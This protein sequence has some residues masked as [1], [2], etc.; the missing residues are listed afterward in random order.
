MHLFDK[1]LEQMRIRI[2][3]VK[4]CFISRDSEVDFPGKAGYQMT[5][6]L[7]QLVNASVSYEHVYTWGYG[8]MKHPEQLKGIVGPLVRSEIDVGGVKLFYL[9]KMSVF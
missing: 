2:R 7:A 1:L 9:V 6:L 8:D 5:N 3:N 4:H